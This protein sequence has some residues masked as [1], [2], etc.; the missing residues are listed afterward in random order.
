M[1]SRRRLL[2]ATGALLLAGCSSD[3]GESTEID[4]SSDSPADEA[5]GAAEDDVSPSAT[6]SGTRTGEE[7]GPTTGTTD[8]SETASGTN[9][10]VAREEPLVVSPTAFETGGTIPEKYTG[11][12]EDVSPPLAV[13]SAPSSA[14]TLAL[15]VDDPDANEYDHWLIWNIPGDATEVPEGV[16]QTETVD[17]LDGAR[18][19][20]NNFGEIGYRG[21]LPPADDDAHTYRFTAYAVDTTLEVDA[22]AGR[23]DL[24]SA[25]DGHVLDDH[26]FTAEFDR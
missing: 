9:G 7:A 10:G 16:P 8:G 15:V 11:V 22:G 6:D 2:C 19:G 21:P 26:R 24:E 1:V 23:A 14:E 20:T 13:E 3:P 18:Q 12:G 5:D 4:E 25:L 17:A